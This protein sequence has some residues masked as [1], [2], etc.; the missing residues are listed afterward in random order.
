MY[1]AP[2]PLLAPYLSAYTLTYPQTISIEQMVLPTASNS[3]VY[4]LGDNALHG[5]LRGVNTKAVQIG[6]YAS[7]FQLLMLV[8]F[9]P[10]GMF[11]FVRIPQS[12]LVDASFSF[13][14]IDRTLH[15][16]LY[17]AF[18][19][20]PSAQALFAQLD[21]IFLARLADTSNQP[22]QL[23]MEAITVTNGM[24]RTKELAQSVFYSEKQLGR[25]FQAQLGTSPK[26]YARIVRIN[27]ALRLLKYGSQPISSIYEATGH[28][29]A[30]HFIHDFQAI[31]G[32]TPSEYLHRMSIYYNDEFKL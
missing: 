25:F 9:R 12:E 28:H 2:H 26:T 17:E 19:S 7:Q 1:V 16:A 3:L 20:A 14:A 24:I 30:S 5:G 27:H 15:T 11:P 22:F 31:C 21:S 6:G 29:D 32:I 18:L 23:A 4:A 8:E 10:G 13:D